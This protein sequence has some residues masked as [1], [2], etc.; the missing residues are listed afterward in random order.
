MFC[1]LNYSRR[2]TSLHLENDMVKYLCR[3]WIWLLKCCLLFLQAG[4][5]F[6]N[7]S[8]SVAELWLIS[9][10]VTVGDCSSIMLILSSGL[11]L[12]RF[13]SMEH[14][15]GRQVFWWSAP[16]AQ[17]LAS[18]YLLKIL[19]I[20]CLWALHACL[21]LSESFSADNMFSV[22]GDNSGLLDNGTKWKSSCKVKVTSYKQQEA[23]HL[24]R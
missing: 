3:H 10:K 9:S 12:N 20:F 14:L 21:W 1:S 18:S 8:V 22:K 16:T 24:Y 17:T 2:Q 6:V 11:C 23:N 19:Q 4:C 5:L 13:C 15:L 7:N